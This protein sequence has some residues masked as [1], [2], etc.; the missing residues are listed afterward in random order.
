MLIAILAAVIGGQS[1]AAVL[2]GLSA[3]A[4]VSLAEELLQLTPD[5]LQLVAE[6]HGSIRQLVTSLGDELIPAVAAKA[7]QNWIAANGAAAIAREP[8]I[9]SES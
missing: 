4:W 8:G 7:A 5:A 1:L 9:S 2:G 6:L 3:A